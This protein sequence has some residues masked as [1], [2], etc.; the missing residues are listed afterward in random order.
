[1]LAAFLPLVAVVGLQVFWLVSLQRTSALAGQIV[2]SSFLDAVATEVLYA[3][4][5]PAERALDVPPAFFTQ[6]RLDRAASHFRKREV[7]GAKSLFAV[8]FATEGWG[9]ILVYDPVADAMRPALPSDET[10]AI[11]VAC[12]P[13]KLMQS[14][15][16]PLDSPRLYTEERDGAN[17][18]VLNPITDSSARVVGVAGLTL[19][20]DYFARRLIPS[21]V[22]TALA[23]HFPKDGGA[24]VVVTVRDG[25]GNTLFSTDPLERRPA[26][27]ER[28][29]PFVF[30]DHRIGIRSRGLTPEQLARV[31]FAFNLS[32][33][34]VAAACLAGGLA[35]VIRSAAQ[36]TRL[37]KMK[38][39]F[40]SNVSHELRTP[41]ASIRVFGELLRLGRVASP[42]KVREYGEYIETEG[43]RLSSLVD[44]ILD[45]ARIESG[46]KEYRFESGD[47]GK[48]VAGVLE[49]FEVRLRHLG[50]TLE[51]RGPE[52]PLPPARIDPA[53]LGQALNNLLD[54][55]VKYS[56][57]S[58]WVGVRLAREG[59]EIVMAVEDRGVGIPP[60]E[61][62][63]V[64]DRFHRA[65]TSLVHDVRGSGLG[66]SIVRHVT[67]AHGGS[68]TVESEPGRGSVFTIRLPLSFE[69]REV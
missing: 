12:S 7:E 2:L 33:S 47:V 34:L 22:Q 32:L 66:L 29:F 65:G 38:S 37:S 58:R 13:W 51:F 62:A 42:E 41:L 30:T 1:M 46:R 50:F 55:A 20:A 6:D 36:Q 43:R 17:R 14:N 68:V 69:T 54:N 63:R 57:D 61:L 19:D 16:I 44:N 67:E 39:D 25:Q 49:T 48:V 53:A 21:A 28:P 56:G 11:T 24:G 35:L 3:Y 52:A 26:G 18:L 15:A 9:T 31:S 23:R 8:R 64:F 27:T 5:P 10:R 40:V 45:F 59:E 60:D 4:G